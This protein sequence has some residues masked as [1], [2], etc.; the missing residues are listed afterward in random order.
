[1]F[2]KVIVFYSVVEAVFY[3]DGRMCLHKVNTYMQSG[4]NLV[5]FYLKVSFPYKFIL[6]TGITPVI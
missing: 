2:N 1:M 5:I 3:K 4:S 6:L